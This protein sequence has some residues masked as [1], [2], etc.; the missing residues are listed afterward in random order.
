MAKQKSIKKNALLNA[1]RTTMSIIFP[2][3]TFPYATR[4]LLPAGIGKVNFAS[5]IISYFTMIAGLGIGTYGIREA[6]KRRD[7]KEALSKVS[8]ELFLVNLIS[9]V[10]AYILLVVALIFIRKFQDYRNLLIIFSA[11]IFFTTIGIEWLYTALEE[12]RYITIRSILFQFISL[13]LLFIFVQKKDDYLKYAGISVFSNVGSN[14]CNLIHSRRYINWKQKFQLNLSQHMKSVFVLFGTRVAAGIY[15]VLDT[16]M[17]G[18]IKTDQDVGYYTAANKL[19]RVVVTVVVSVTSVLLPRLSYY[20]KNNEMSGF[21]TLF[22]K[23]LNYILLFSIPAVCGLYALSDNIII[24]LSGKDFLP[25]IPIM[26]VICLIVFI[27]P[28]SGLLGTQLFIPL[29]KERYTL[30]A[31]ILGAVLNFTLNYFLIPR[32][33]AVGAA[34][35]SVIAESFIAIVYFILAKKYIDYKLLI[36]PVFQ[37]II[38]SAFMFIGVLFIKKIISNVIVCT[39]IAI[40]CGTIIYTIVLLLVHNVFLVNIIASIKQQGVRHGKIS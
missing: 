5:G 23:S 21:Q 17:L 36:K 38:A 4:I 26:H 39:I 30:F 35:A 40:C 31:M 33:A 6:A 20:V 2:L 32:Y 3:I 8:K 13:V 7:D 18:F 24:L 28:F 9:T 19:T 11:T 10:V 14:L 27:V 15:T 25:A 37:Y 1:F 29:G 16:I 12:Y 34:I 22:N